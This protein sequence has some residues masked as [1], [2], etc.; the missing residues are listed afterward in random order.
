MSLLALVEE[1][2]KVIREEKRGY[3]N[4]QAF[5]LLQH[6]GLNSEDCLQ[7]AQHFGKQYHQVVGSISE[8]SAFA[9]YTDKQW[10]SGYR[11]QTPIFE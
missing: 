8:L 3:I 11:Q 5:P 6:L 1:T 2:V 10:V 7:L 9:A 4:E